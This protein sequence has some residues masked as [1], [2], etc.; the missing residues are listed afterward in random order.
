MS[1]ILGLHLGHD[2]SVA[3]LQD[4]EPIF[5]LS[6]ERLAREK[7]YFGFPFRALEAA[8]RFVGASPGDFH[9]IAL[10]TTELPGVIGPDEMRRRFV[11]E[12]S[13]GALR[14]VSQAKGVLK[15]LFGKRGIEEQQERES[16]ARAI[17]HQGLLDYGFDLR[18]LRVF[19][20]HLC[21]AAS[22]FLPSPFADAMVVTSDGRGDGLSATLGFAKGAHLNRK[23]AISDVDSIGQLYAAITFF[24]GFRPNRHEGKITGLA[25]FGDPSELGNEF[26]EH[27]QWNQGGSYSFQLPAKYRLSRVEEFSDFVKRMPLSL[28]ERVLLHSQNDLTTLLYNANWYGLLAYLQDVAAHVKSENVAAGV[29][30]FVERVCTEFVRRNLP[31]Q[32]TPVVLAG[33]VHANVRVNQKIRKLEGVTDIYVQPAMADEGLSLGAA[34][35]AFAEH[36]KSNGALSSASRSTQVGHTYLGTSYSKQEIIAACRAEGVP[37]REVS[38]TEQFIARQIHEGSV[39]GYFKGRI[40]Y[41]PRALG[42]RSIIVRPTDRSVNESLNNRFHRT[43]FMPFAPS[44]IAE[45]AHEYLRNYSEQHAAAKYMTTTY[46]IHPE[47]Q[48]EIQAVVHVDGTARPQVVS[49]SDE[50][51]YHRIIEEYAKLSGIPV[52]VNTSFNM[53]EEPIVCTPE[54]AIRSFKVNCVD[55]LVMEDIVVTNQGD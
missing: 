55:V 9:C 16:Q 19:D 28:K 11:R 32:P 44:I 45:R 21:H 49:Q 14:R 48:N 42:H 53:H 1:L 5:C 15:N 50:P 17:L 4:G 29:Q 43:E 27:V 31:S 24:L 22:A 40:E 47:K 33:G 38:D 12:R 36:A 10:D 8:M 23:H 54:D 46:D 34:L 13:K 51:S 35:L 6:E 30:F 25:A 52:V 20:H 7:M 39:V 18:R 41:G 26:Y 2:A 3:V 37:F